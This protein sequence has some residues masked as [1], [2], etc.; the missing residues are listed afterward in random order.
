MRPE[1]SLSDWELVEVTVVLRDLSISRTASS[2]S[3]EQS[4]KASARDWD[5]VPFLAGAL[6][7][8]A[9][10]VAGLVSMGQTKPQNLN[11]LDAI[12]SEDRR[13]MAHQGGYFPTH[14]HV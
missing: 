3:T 2:T 11:T 14:I 5:E 7:L 8:V 10:P 13:A 4:S 12:G 6:R 9:M 1:R